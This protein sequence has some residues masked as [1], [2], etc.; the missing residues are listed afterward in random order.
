MKK[1][2]SNWDK[3]SSWITIEK[4]VTVEQQMREIY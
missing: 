1:G 2:N 4:N 3:G